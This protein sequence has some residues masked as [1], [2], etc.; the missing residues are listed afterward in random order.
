MWVWPLHFYI[1]ENMSSQILG[2][3]IVEAYSYEDTTRASG[4]WKFDIGLASYVQRAL[5]RKMV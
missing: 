3:F 4:N 1:G 2:Y 5:K